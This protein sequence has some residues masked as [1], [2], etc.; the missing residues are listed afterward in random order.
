MLFRYALGIP[1]EA[2]RNFMLMRNGDIY[3][4]D[5]E[6]IRSDI[7]FRNA[8]KKK[9]CEIIIG[10]INSNAGWKKLSMRMKGWLTSYKKTS[11]CIEL[12]IGNSDWLHERLVILQDQEATAKIF[13]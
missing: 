12:L 11:D 9:K 13:E 5:E 10:Y 1:D 3:S 2:D 8:L 7:N 6:G 4:V